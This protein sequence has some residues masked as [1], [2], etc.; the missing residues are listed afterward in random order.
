MSEEQEPWDDAWWEEDTTPAKIEPVRAALLGN[1]AGA[2]RGIPTDDVRTFESQLKAAHKDADIKVFDGKA[3]G[4]MNP[5]NKDG[6][7]AAASTEAWSRIDA[8][9]T[10]TLKGK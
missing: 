3:H 4:F 2:D 9:F 1:F 7:D 8:F 5:N 6:F 10:R